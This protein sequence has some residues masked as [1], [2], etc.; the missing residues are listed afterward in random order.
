M[1]ELDHRRTYQRVLGGNLA[2]LLGCTAS[3]IWVI[4][5]TPNPTCLQATLAG[6]SALRAPA[7]GYLKG[8]KMV[9]HLK[10]KAMAKHLQM[11]DSLQRIRRQPPEI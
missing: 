6:P 7:A 10:D 9:E 4:T 1:V 2:N 11:A 8:K 3:H 5:M